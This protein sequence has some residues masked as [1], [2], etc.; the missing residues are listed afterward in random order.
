MDFMLCAKAPR[1][2]RLVWVVDG[3]DNPLPKLTRYYVSQ[4]GGQLVK[5][6][7]PL[8]KK[9]NEW[10]RIGIQTGR[11]VTPCNRLDHENLPPIDYG[12]YIEEAEKL[13]LG[14]A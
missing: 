3:V 12:Y 8:A 2:S 6:M 1:G 11:V 7:P 9:P 13:T 14:L 5:I 10:R 4:E